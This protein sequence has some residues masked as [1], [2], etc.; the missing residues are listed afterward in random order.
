M[1]TLIACYKMFCFALLCAFTFPILAIWRA[2]FSKTDLF[3]AIPKTFHTLTCKIFQIK[4]ETVGKPTE[5]HAIY[6]G[7][8]LSYID[9][10]VIGS[11]LDA[12]FISKDDVKSWPV[13]GWL[14]LLA[15]TVFISRSRDAA[16][17]C[18]NDISEM[19]E[20]DRS[21]ILFPEG[22]SSRGSNVIPFK[23]SLF[24]LF[25]NESIKDKLLIQ[26]FTLSIQ[27]IDEK[28]ISKPEDMDRYA[29]YGDMELTPHL[30]QIA[31]LKGAL[32]R[33]NFHPP[34]PA[35]KFDNRK[36]FAKTCYE[37]VKAG[38]EEN[39]PIPLDSA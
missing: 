2:C 6:L 4:I 25:L 19:I 37:D 18:I 7:N 11:V 34:Y 29:W 22:T 1:R 30:W 17:K 36:I 13:F 38:L 8:H 32:I 5:E 24:E 15:E 9:I 10:P 20:R 27:R 21:L 23:S 39:S 31:N 12:T 3:H 14:A 33:I 35:N 26:P 16:Q 28:E